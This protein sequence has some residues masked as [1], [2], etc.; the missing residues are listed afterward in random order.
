MTDALVRNAFEISGSNQL[1]TASLLGISRNTL[2][3]HLGHLGLIKPRRSLGAG[4][5]R[6]PANRSAVKGSC[7]SAI[8]NLAIWG[9]S[10]PGSR[11]RPA[12][13]AAALAYC[14]VNSPPVH[15]CCMP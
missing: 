14:G 6:G 5:Q 3:T 1:Q 7:A 8:R 15:S 10:R 9:S 12:L 2:R 4:G 11:W 13:P